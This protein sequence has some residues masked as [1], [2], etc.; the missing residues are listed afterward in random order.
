MCPEDTYVSKCPACFVS[1]YRPRPGMI[2]ACPASIPIA[3]KYRGPALYH[4]YVACPYRQGSS[5]ARDRRKRGHWHMGM[6][7]RE[8]LPGV[9]V[10]PGACYVIT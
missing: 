5:V 4:G 8:T 3:S 6:A 1:L 2:Q 10:R 7:R 9:T